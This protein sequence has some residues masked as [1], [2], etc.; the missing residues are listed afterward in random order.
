MEYAE[1]ETIP[2][3]PLLPSVCRRPTEGLLLLVLLRRDLPVVGTVLG[4]S[5]RSNGSGFSGDLS[6][7]RGLLCAYGRLDEA[8]EIVRR[9]RAITLVVVDSAIPYRNLEFRQ[10]YL[11]GLSMAASEIG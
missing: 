10:L 4:G 1:P 8:R 2:P 9:L 6:R 11:S 7:S 5:R 3:C